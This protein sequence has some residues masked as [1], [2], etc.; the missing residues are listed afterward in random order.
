MPPGQFP[1]QQEGAKPHYFKGDC[2]IISQAMKV[3]DYRKANDLPR[4]KYEEALEDIDLYTCQRL[5]GHTRWCH[6]DD[7]P[8][9]TAQPVAANKTKAKGCSTCGHHHE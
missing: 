7:R 6:D 1:Y 3:S 2:D 5:G 8:F 4:S 9:A